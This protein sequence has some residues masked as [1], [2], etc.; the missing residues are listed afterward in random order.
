MADSIDGFV[1]DFADTLTARWNHGPRVFHNALRSPLFTDRDFM[2]AVRGAARDYIADPTARVAPGRVYLNHEA[3]K[4]E[5][6]GPLLPRGSEDCEQYMGRVRRD[7]PQ[8]EVGIVLDG[9][10]KYVPAMR[11]ALVP[12]LHGLFSRVGYPARRNHLCIYAGTYRSTPFGIHRDDCHV[13]MFCI[14]GSKAVAFWPRPYFDEKRE[15][16]VD[17]KVRARVEDHLGVATVL[18]MGP[19]DVLYWSADDYHVAVSDTNDFQAALSVGI[20]HHGSSAEMMTSLDVLADVTRIQGLDIPGLPASSAAGRLSA[21]DLRA[22][23]AGFF[24]RWDRLRDMVDRPGEAEYRA[25]RRAV[26]LGGDSIL[27]TGCSTSLYASQNGAAGGSRWRTVFN[28]VDPSSY[29]AVTSVRG[30]AP[31]AF[32]GRIERIKGTHT[33]IQIAK[34]SGRPLAIAG[35]VA[36][37]EYFRTEIAPHLDDRQVTYIGEVDDAAKNRLLGDSAALLMPIEWDEPFGIVMAEAFACG[38][39]VIGFPRGSVPEVV[40]DGINGFVVGNVAEASQAVK[41][42]DRIDREAVRRDCDERF[43]CDAIVGAY[44]Q[45]YQ[46]AIG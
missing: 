20:Y 7:R 42:L 17:G 46:E 32:L 28:C 6:L 44:E 21:E 23:M 14:S 10:E 8:D 19:L 2:T 27:F 36:D 22:P 11:D 33:A 9:C 40:R 31:L 5:Q 30:N 26:R 45:L 39:P 15:L 4:P 24:E 29:V 3:I 37:A 34:A 38:T 12:T 16:F 13:L 43:S 35:N 1:P 25:L 41:R 18:E